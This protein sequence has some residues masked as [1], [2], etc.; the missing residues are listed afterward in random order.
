VAEEDEFGVDDELDNLQADLDQTGLQDAAT[1]AS[2]GNRA[3]IIGGAI[4]GVVI[5]GSVLFGMKMFSNNDVV[6]QGGPVSAEQQRREEKPKKKKKVKYVRLFSQLTGI[7][8]T[9]VLKE[10]SIA[11][12]KFK[13]EQNGNN[14]AVLVD[15]D[16][17]TEVRNLLAVK[18][19]PTGLVK[20]Y[21]L[22][23]ESQTLGVTEFD[24]RVRFL[25]AL[26]GEL[27]K[28]IM[29]FD[30][31]EDAK[32]QI[33]LPEQRLF[34]VTQPPVT[35]SILV[36]RT[37]GE[38]V[39]DD[40]VFSII[41][42]VSNAVENLQQENVSVI[43]TQGFVLSDGIFERMAQRRA[44][45]FRA[46]QKEPEPIQ[47]TTREEAVGQPMIPQFDKIREWFDLKWEFEQRL[48]RR[49]MKHLMGVLPLGAY[50]VSATSDLGP[51][52]N[53]E[54]VDIRRLTISVVV[55]NNNDELFLDQQTKRQ[56]FSTVAGATG[57][58]KGRDQ[59]IL[60]RADFTLLSDEEK[61]QIERLRKEQAREQLMR[62]IMLIGGPIV[63]TLG[64]VIGLVA[65]F[66]RR[67]ALKAL[68][69][70]VVQAPEPEEDAFEVEDEIAV[71]PYLERL[72]S[73]AQTEPELVAALMQEWLGN[74]APPAQQAAAPTD[75]PFTDF[76]GDQET[77]A[78]DTGDEFG[79]DD[80]FTDEFGDDFEDLG[81]ED[82][83]AEDLAEEVT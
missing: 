75:E 13:T 66:R 3:M 77:A 7:E 31:I 35:S 6:K 24:K 29:Q 23:D 71:T 28:A 80:L 54:I 26:S 40:T 12:F 30:A 37:P 18:G 33:V 47:A 2:T 82:E 10:L 56:I 32:V 39:T 34:S 51:L 74:S 79:D 65:Y 62:R 44:G 48:V 61:A 78:A 69:K 76:G 19:L 22:L 43:D 68:E 14:F 49:T 53:G 15:E 64:T 81:F 70:P 21:E 46:P 58:V 83:F 5:L 4:A 20:G 59:I 16:E 45:T 67:R 52:E 57:Y 55:D 8:A 1:G 17:E 38:D 41:Q 42:L 9:R 63:L 72:R 11:G 25:R 27:E 36:R 60:S 73:T 50:K